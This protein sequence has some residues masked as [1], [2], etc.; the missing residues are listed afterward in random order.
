MFIFSTCVSPTVLHNSKDLLAEGFFQGGLK[1]D[2]IL[3]HREQEICDDR[4]NQ[5]LVYVFKINNIGIL[6][7]DETNGES[8]SGWVW[9]YRLKIFIFILCLKINCI[10]RAEDVGRSRLYYLWYYLDPTVC[11]EFNHIHA[12]WDL[13]Y[14]YMFSENFFPSPFSL[15]KINSKC[16]KLSASSSEKLN[17]NQI[18]Q[19]F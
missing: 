5:R 3:L 8:V 16:S 19:A 17:I 11:W 18:K 9:N 4:L 10:S 1:I 13:K 12:A 6:H 2:L 15:I 7:R 14:D